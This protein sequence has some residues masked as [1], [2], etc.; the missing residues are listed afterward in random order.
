MQPYQDQ[1]EEAHSHE[2]RPEENSFDELAK[3]MASG[4]IPRGQALKLVGAALLGGTLLSIPGLAWAKPKPVTKCSKD[5]KCPS[6]ES[7]CSRTCTDLKTDTNNC[8]SCGHACVSGE[9]CCSG[10]CT[11]LVTTSNCGS[12]GTAC[13]A[14]TNGSVTCSGGSCVITCD[15]GYF[16]CGDQCVN[17]STDVNNCGC[18]GTTCTG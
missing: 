16:N 13:T 2:G 7:C 4:A 9:S 12:C 10:T 17:T 14:P 15:S 1:S 11:P 8:G 6:G 3:G 18:C 5:S